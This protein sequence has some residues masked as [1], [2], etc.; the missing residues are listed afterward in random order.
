M[1]TRTQ[2]TVKSHNSKLFNTS[3]STSSWILEVS[4]E[5]GSGN[6]CIL[7]LSCFAQIFSILCTD[8]KKSE[9]LVTSCL[10]Q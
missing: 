10:D 7:L 3:Q 1:Y 6:T 5:V 4:T 9:D 2:T 8:W